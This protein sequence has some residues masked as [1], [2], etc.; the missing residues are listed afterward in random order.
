MA[1]KKKNQKQKKKNK[2]RR[3]P[4]RTCIACR[5]KA[6]KKEMMRF[7]LD[8][9][10]NPQLDPTGRI[11]GRGANLCSSVECF[12]QAIENNSFARSWRTK[13]NNEKLKDLRKEVEEYLN[14]DKSGQQR[15]SKTIRVKEETVEKKLGKSITRSKQQK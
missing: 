2:E 12:D 11:Q 9:D 6:P 14:S 1:K 15:K 5:R 3:V 10:G 8:P 7:V 13:V 4:E